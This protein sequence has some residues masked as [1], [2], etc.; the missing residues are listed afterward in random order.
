MVKTF[1]YQKNVKDIYQNSKSEV[2]SELKTC[3][4]ILRL[5]FFLRFV[6]ISMY[7]VLNILS[8]YTYFYI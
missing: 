5:K 3:I 8:E 2:A 6:F 7:S 1:K 4:F